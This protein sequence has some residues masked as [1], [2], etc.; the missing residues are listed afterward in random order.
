[1]G[2]PTSCTPLSDH[3]FTKSSLLLDQSHHKL[4]TSNRDIGHY[5]QKYCKT[6]SVWFYW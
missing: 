1:V 4:G 5:E 3:A 2:K 6:H